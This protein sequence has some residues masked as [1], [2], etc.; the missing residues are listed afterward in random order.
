M[1][2]CISHSDDVHSHLPE[3]CDTFCLDE[4]RFKD[5][6]G[7]CEFEGFE[8]DIMDKY[9]T[10][11]VLQRDNEQDYACSPLDTD[12]NKRTCLAYDEKDKDAD[13]IA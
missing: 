10:A 6:Y 2:K 1:L 5:T 3:Y 13:S 8:Q 7:Y 12:T 9:G 11:Y 4:Y